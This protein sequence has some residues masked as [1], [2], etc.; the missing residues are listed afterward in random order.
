MRCECHRWQKDCPKW[1]TWAV[2]GLCKEYESHNRIWRDYQKRA[3]IVTPS[4]PRKKWI[5]A[6][7][8]GLQVLQH[9]KLR[10]ISGAIK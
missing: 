8:Q 1:D 5:N 3:I 10:Q 6:I 9:L 7:R 4:K 2:S